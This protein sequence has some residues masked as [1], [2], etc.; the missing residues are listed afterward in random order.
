MCQP[1]GNPADGGLGEV[2]DAVGDLPDVH[3]FAGEDEQRDGDE[4][5]GVDP[6]DHL[7]R[8][9]DDRE[10]VDQQR[11][12]RAEA[13]GNGD[14]DADQDQAEEDGEER[15]HGVSF[16]AESPLSES[17]RVARV[18]T[19]SSTPAMTTGR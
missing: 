11:D 10:I 4:G 6:G 7:L 15:Q 8:D 16:P 12:Q 14:R 2:E 17:S 9:D 18:W 5:E 19:I 3:Q 13:D 1:A